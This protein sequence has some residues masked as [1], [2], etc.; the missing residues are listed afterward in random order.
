[1]KTTISTEASQL[2]RHVGSAITQLGG[3][4]FLRRAVA[5]PASRSATVESAL[6]PLGVFDLRPLADQVELEAAAEVCRAAGWHGLPYPLA[7]RYAHPDDDGAFMLVGPGRA[8]GLHGDV[9]L[10]W[11]GLDLRG[12]TFEIA[13]TG[14]AVGTPLAPFVTEVDARATSDQDPHAAALIVTLQMWWLLGL[15]ERV[16]HMTYA[17][18]GDRV[19]FGHPIREYQGLQ[20]MFGDAAVAVRTFKEIAKYTLWSQF[21]RRRENDWLVDAVSL[22]VAGLESS[23]TVLR[24]AHQLHGAIGF[25][26]EH[27]LSWLSRLSHGIRRLPMGQSQ[28]E[29][30][31]LALVTEHGFTTVVARSGQ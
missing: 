27:D 28:T 9:P 21:Q 25:C 11:A 6:Q 13:R 24:I 2:G 1:M 16:N 8:V 26:D 19:Q 31:L 4:D 7:E 29:A 23:H 10:A 14:A 18:M 3:I 30:A 15:L 20:F 17:Y 12:R 5:S 22:R